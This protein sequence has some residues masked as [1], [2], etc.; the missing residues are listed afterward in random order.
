MLIQYGKAEELET[1][2]EKSVE[3]PTSITSGKKVNPPGN[4]FIVSVF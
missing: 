3:E 1:W 4:T 2:M